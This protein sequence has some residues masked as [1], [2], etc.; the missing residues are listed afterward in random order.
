MAQEGTP[1][2][3]GVDWSFLGEYQSIVYSPEEIAKMTPAMRALIEQL[4]NVD[5]L[6]RKI[7]DEPE[8]PLQ[9]PVVYSE[10]F[11]TAYPIP[12]WKDSEKDKATERL[13]LDYI[14]FNHKY[15][16]WL[17]TLFNQIGHSGGLSKEQRGDVLLRIVSDLDG[18][19]ELELDQ[20]DPVPKTT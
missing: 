9:L 2:G 1:N 4:G 8:A 11:D 13:I 5:P 20:R 17:N 18:Q 16:S 19:L 14:W 12:E 3:E 15:S 6:Q 7:P 10:A